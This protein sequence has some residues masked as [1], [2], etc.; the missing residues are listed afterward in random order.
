MVIFGLTF[1]VTMWLIAQ[2][3]GLISKAIK[4]KATRVAPDNA[5]VAVDRVRQVHTFCPWCYSNSCKL[6]IAPCELTNPCLAIVECRRRCGYKLT[7]GG[8][9]NEKDATIAVTVRHHREIEHVKEI[10]WQA[11]QA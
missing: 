11:S 4:A 9:R 2:S 3:Y 6:R 10:L 1:A 7:S 5:I 8:K